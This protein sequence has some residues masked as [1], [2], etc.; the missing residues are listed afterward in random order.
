MQSDMSEVSDVVVVGAGP[1]GLLTALG[2][3]RT[4]RSVTVIEAEPRINDSPRAAV[5]FPTTIKILDRLGLLE[6]TLAI[7]Y[8]S[9]SFSFHLLAS[10]EVVHIPDT[11][12]P[13]SPY[14]YNAHF[15][16]HL[17]AQLVLRH[18][19][20]LPGTAM[21]WNTRLVGLSQDASG[22]TLS[23][24]TPRGREDVRARWV[25][26]ADGARST[27]RSLLSLP[28][29]GHTWPDRFVAT[30]VSYD[31]ESYGFAP[32]NMLADAVHWAVVARLGR[33]NLWRVTFSEDASLPEADIPR[34]IAEK[35]SVLLPDPSAPYRIVAYS[36][37][38]VHERCAPTF[39]V[40]R[41]LLAGDAAHA[42]NPCGGMG[43]TGGVIDAAALSDVL[44]A[45]LADRAPESV[46]DFYATERRRVFLE[47]SSPV[48]S[49]FKRRMSEKDPARQRADFDEFRRQAEDPARLS[50]STALSKLVEGQPM[51]V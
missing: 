30:N 6:D 42:C 50:L 35:Y 40:G 14:P 34:R 49:D 27:V 7:A 21:R 29:E 32:A 25:V 43:L 48:A 37:Y 8:L 2:V 24:E 28:F 1:V 47:V 36:P 44:A 38:R 17:L 11:F 5:Y 20:A 41:T 18:F 15:G 13:D 4:G 12:P 39:R 46:L 45:V 9:R 3:A 19:S 31:F 23:V 16:Q 33:E 51:P 22:A 26:G 10:G